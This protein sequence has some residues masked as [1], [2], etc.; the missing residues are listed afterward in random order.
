MSNKFEFPKHKELF[1]EGYYN[2]ENEETTQFEDVLSSPLNDRFDRENPRYKGDAIEF[3]PDGTT[4]G[5][6]VNGGILQNYRKVTERS[7]TDI[8]ED[9][10]WRK[11]QGMKHEVSNYFNHVSKNEK[12]MMNST[13]NLVMRQ[14][15]NRE[16]SFNDDFRKKYIVNEYGNYEKY[17][18]NSIKIER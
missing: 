6:D 8:L 14:R 11:M 4:K 15:L 10:W 12:D 16:I 9:D 13:K 1:Q 2:E 3:Q 5:L 18:K 17:T 7:V